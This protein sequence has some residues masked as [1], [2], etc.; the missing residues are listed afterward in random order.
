MPFKDVGG[1]SI[2]Y[3]DNGELEEHGGIQLRVYVSKV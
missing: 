3:V 1:G 2:T